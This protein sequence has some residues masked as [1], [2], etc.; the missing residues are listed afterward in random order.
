MFDQH[1]SS[2]CV[3]VWSVVLEKVLI[4]ATSEALFSCSH[5]PALR[6]SRFAPNS[7]KTQ[8]QMYNRYETLYVT[9]LLN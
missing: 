2:V 9:I 8:L 5:V 4:A 7:D 1:I 3:C 6:N